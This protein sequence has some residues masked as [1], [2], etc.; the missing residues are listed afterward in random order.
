MATGGRPEIGMKAPE[1]SLMGTRGK[2]VELKDFIGRKHLVIYFYPKDSTPGCTVEACEFRDEYGHFEEFGTVI[3]GV[4]RDTMESH[5]SFSSKH[6]L[7]YLLLS[8]PD[9]EVCKAY[10]VFGTKSFMGREFLGI[11]RTTFVIDK[12]GTIRQIYPR[13]KVRE[14]AA[15]VLEFVKQQLA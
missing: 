1:F 3:L 15:E 4:S 13:V 6:S 11:H 7:P 8:D 9:S 5:E 10:G 2:K 12:T 14:H